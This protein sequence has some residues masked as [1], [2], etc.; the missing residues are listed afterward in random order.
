MTKATRTEGGQGKQAALAACIFKQE[1][2]VRRHFAKHALMASSIL[3]MTIAASAGTVAPMPVVNPTSIQD[4]Y[5]QINALNLDT[6]DVPI[7]AQRIATLYEE[8]ISPLQT[9]ERLAT[10]NSDDLTLIFRA[11]DTASFYLVEPRY[12]TDMELD[13]KTLESRGAAQDVDFAELYGAYVGLRQFDKAAGL[14]DAH[15][16][17]TVPALPKLSIKDVGSSEHEVLQVSPTDGSVSSAHVDFNKGPMIIVVGH[18]Y[19]HF[20][21]NAVAVIEG[22]PT[23]NDVFQRR[24]IWITPPSRNLDNQAVQEWNDKHTAIKFDI[25]Y[26]RD[27]WKGL[28]TWETPVF[29]FYRDGILKD[30]VIGWPKGGNL[31]ALRKGME[32]IGISDSHMTKVGD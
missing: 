13:L 30:T 26:S 14:K 5:N 12:V 20:S 2:A 17:M 10:L 9:T 28:S 3:A 32:S 18:P 31:P 23:L 16:G 1:H 24:S 6:I 25:A 15:P 22:N 27:A 11:A 4:A 29:Y 21:Q 7:K 19:C 8:K